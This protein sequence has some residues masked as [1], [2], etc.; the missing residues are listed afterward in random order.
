[1]KEKRTYKAM[2]YYLAIGQ[3]GGCFW[4]LAEHTSKV[5]GDGW[6]ATV[7][8]ADIEARKAIDL[9]LAIH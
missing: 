1:M 3:A 6:A 4:W 5:I 7:K 8:L 2:E 9:L